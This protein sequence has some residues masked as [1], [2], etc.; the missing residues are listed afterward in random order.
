MRSEQT[1]A[2]QMLWRLLRAKRLS[3]FKFRRQQPVGPFIVDFVCLAEALIVEADG[4][5]HIEN[6]GDTQRT[7]FLEAR[8]YRVLRFWNADILARPD[9]VAQQVFR[10]LTDPSPRSRKRASRP[11]PHGERE[12]SLVNDC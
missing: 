11:L 1:E 8:G 12:E 4:S 3:A 6:A 9:D 2:E 5:Q 10:A 7:A